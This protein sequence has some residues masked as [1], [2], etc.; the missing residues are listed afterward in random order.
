MMKKL[1]EV[2][3]ESRQYKIYKTE[4]NKAIGHKIKTFRVAFDMTKFSLAERIGITY[5]QLSNYE[6]AKSS[7]TVERLYKIAIIFNTEIQNLLPTNESLNQI[8][9]NIVK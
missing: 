4:I 5:Q 2:L 3:K 1:E 6:N 9:N 8:Y 7:I